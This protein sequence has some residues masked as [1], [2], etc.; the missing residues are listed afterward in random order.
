MRQGWEK[1]TDVCD[2]FWSAGLIVQFVE[3]IVVRMGKPR[4]I[5][6]ANPPVPAQRDFISGLQGANV[7]KA[8]ALVYIAQG[9]PLALGKIVR[10]LRK[11]GQ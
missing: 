5:Q 8:N 4:R 7:E 6:K 10:V 2:Q 9:V 11:T 1:G 3:V